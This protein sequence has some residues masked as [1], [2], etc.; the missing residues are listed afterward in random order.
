MDEVTIANESLSQQSILVVDD[1]I[2]LLEILKTGLSL[3]GYRCKAVRSA[4][5]ALELLNQDSFDIMVIDIVF[6]DMSGFQLST[7]AKQIK[8]DIVP[9]SNH[10]Q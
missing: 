8:P 6:P 2:S 4:T 10:S 3:R 5:I 1:D 7:K 9:S